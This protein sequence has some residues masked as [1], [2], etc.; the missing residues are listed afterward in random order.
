MYGAQNQY[1]LFQSTTTSFQNRNLQLGQDTTQFL[2]GL[3]LTVRKSSNQ[4]FTEISGLTEARKQS[5]LCNPEPLSDP[6]T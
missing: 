3:L 4:I 2:I 6:A 5:G 1:L